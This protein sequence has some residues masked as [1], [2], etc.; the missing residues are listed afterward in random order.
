[1]DDDILCPKYLKIIWKYIYIRHLSD[2]PV[3]RNGYKTVPKLYENS[4]IFNKSSRFKKII[5][6]K[7]ATNLKKD[8]ILKKPE[9]LRFAPIIIF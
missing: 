6:S 4:Y 1:M 2:V 5:F 7:N 3:S 9:N 8:Y